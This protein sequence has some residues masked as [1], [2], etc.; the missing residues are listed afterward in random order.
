MSE[1]ALDLSISSY[2]VTSQKNPRQHDH[3][4][5]DSGRASSDSAMSDIHE[6]IKARLRRSPQATSL[7][8]SFLGRSSPTG[9]RALGCSQFSPLAHTRNLSEFPAH[10]QLKTTSSLSP[11]THTELNHQVNYTNPDS[12]GQTEAASGD[13]EVKPLR[14]GDRIAENRVAPIRPFKMY[15]VDPFTMYQNSLMA[16]PGTL[17][18][19]PVSLQSIYDAASPVGFPTFPLTP[20]TTHLL[21]RKRRAEHRDSSSS[22]GTATASSMNVNSSNSSTNSGSITV[23]VSAGNGST[24]VSTSSPVSS[25]EDSAGS[26]SEKRAKTSLDVKK[27]DAYWDRR[28]KNNEAAKR[29]RDARRQKE[30]EIAMRA[31]YLE[32][33]NLKLRAQVTIL[34]NETAKLHY[35]LYNRM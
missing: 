26:D 33:E 15:P 1:A 20:I 24:L 5:N 7:H 2:D 28:R 21:L 30:E 3:V 29:S 35:M 6:D 14:V 34:K 31:A 23:S 10:I 19:P 12:P 25:K 9:V 18:S 32:Q 16:G 27:D 8:P 4:S 17:P 22:S 11:A 13:D